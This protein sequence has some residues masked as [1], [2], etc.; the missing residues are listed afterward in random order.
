M[1]GQVQGGSQGVTS[2][3][4]RVKSESSFLGKTFTSG[5]RFF[6][7]PCKYFLCCLPSSIIPAPLTCARHPCHSNP[8]ATYGLLN[9]SHHRGVVGGHHLLDCY[10]PSTLVVPGALRFK[11]QSDGL[12]G[13]IQLQ[14]V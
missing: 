13:S 1:L 7:C 12:F 3:G 2:E 14:L 9:P 5:S 8:S 4:S 10:S 6:F 11:E